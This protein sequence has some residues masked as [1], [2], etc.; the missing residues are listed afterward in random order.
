MS[1]GEIESELEPEH[2]GS[3]LSQYAAF[4]TSFREGNGNEIPPKLLSAV[5]SNSI[6]T[7][8][9]PASQPDDNALLQGE[10]NR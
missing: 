3:Q 2:L 8:S 10:L 6:S 4:L 5:A 1:G 9:K 7:G